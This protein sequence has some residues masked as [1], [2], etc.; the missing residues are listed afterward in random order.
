MYTEVHTTS[1]RIRAGIQSEEEALLA[2][3]ESAFLLPESPPE[4]SEEPDESPED[5]EPESEDEEPDSPP[6]P[7]SFDAAAAA[8]LALFA[9][10][11]P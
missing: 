10:R 1:T 9:E 7:D 5:D 8:C 4:E 6:E 11:V 2:G 3:F